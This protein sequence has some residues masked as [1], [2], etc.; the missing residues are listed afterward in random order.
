MRVI[1]VI[2]IVLICWMLINF[3]VY[4]KIRGD[5]GLKYVDSDVGY[6]NAL[7]FFKK[8]NNK[9]CVNGVTYD[10]RIAASFKSHL[11]LFRERNPDIIVHFKENELITLDDSESK[12]INES[13]CN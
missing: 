10:N 8:D 13:F 2:L 5:S 6:L 4:F 12:K 11:D 1:I 7:I 3:Y 9:Y